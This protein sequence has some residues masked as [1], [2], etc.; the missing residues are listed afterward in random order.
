MMRTSKSAEN[1][2][3]IIVAA[4]MAFSQGLAVFRFS[5]SGISREPGWDRTSASDTRSKRVWLSLNTLFF[6]CFLVQQQ[7]EATSCTTG[8]APADS[9]NSGGDCGGR[10]TR[11]AEVLRVRKTRSHFFLPEA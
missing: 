6:H 4:E 1:A 5:F 7:A 11:R 8:C 2:S 9:R 10:S 3:L